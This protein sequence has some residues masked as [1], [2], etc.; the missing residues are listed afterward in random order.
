MGAALSHIRLMLLMLAHDWD[1]ILVLEND[2]LV[3]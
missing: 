2:A 3:R 1:L